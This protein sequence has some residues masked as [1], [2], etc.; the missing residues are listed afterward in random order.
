M[1]VHV[2]ISERI[3]TVTLDR[4]PVNALSAETMRE[5]TSVFRELDGDR[6]VSVIVLRATGE[7]VFCAG[8]DINDSERRYAEGASAD[9]AAT[10]LIDPGRVAR[11]CFMA[12]YECSVPVISAVQGF[13][14]GAGL[15]LI[16]CTDIIIASERARFGLPEITVGVLGGGRFLQRLVGVAKM[17]AMFFTGRQVDAAELYRLGAI[18]QVVDHDRLEEVALEYAREIAGKSPIGLR[19]GKISI[20]RAESL[21][22]PDGYRLEQ[23][24]TA[25]VSGYEDAREARDSWRE[26]RE[27][28]WKWR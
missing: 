24:Y 11:E 28:D 25:K 8:A 7:K 3:A 1:T 18:E 27:P 26:K 13:A 6:R 10:D 4:P 21:S 23:D 19:L 5:L 12:V 16:A 20:T 9:T 22:V 17:R 14:L 15:A 2:D